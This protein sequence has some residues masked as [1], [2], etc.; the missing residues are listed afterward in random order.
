MRK[1]FK[2]LGI[3]VAVLVGLIAIALTTVYAI[4]SSRM[5]KPYKV[6]VKPVP[7][8]SDSAS[9]EQGKHIAITRACIDC[10]GENF[11]G[12]TIVDGPFFV[13]YIHGPNITRGKGGRG[14]N[15]KDIDWVRALRHGVSSDGR[16]LVVMPSEKYYHL[17]DEDLGC[18]IAYLKSLPPVDNTMPE[19]SL[20]ALIRTLYVAGEIQM[21]AEMIDHTGPR[22]TSP[23][24]SVSVEY[25]HYMSHTCTGCHGKGFAG[26]AIP[27]APPDWKPAANITSAGNLGKWSETDFI[28]TLR[29]GTTPEGLKLEPKDMPW[30]TF[31]QMTDTELRALYLYLRSVPAKPTGSR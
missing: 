23:P 10:H 30:P 12:R 31:A 13:G 14:G 1:F 29:T 4:S 22:P 21:A 11:G 25:G 6:D 3:G 17:N 2:W 16:A 24:V 15:L 18:L 7:I 20:G 19:T 9:I 8:P 5:S 26:G 28:R 27:G